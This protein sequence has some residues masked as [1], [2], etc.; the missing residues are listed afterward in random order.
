MSG[1]ILLV[2]DSAEDSSIIIS[3]LSGYNILTAHNCPEALRQ[4]DMNPDI[5]LL[6]LDI[7]MPD[8]GGFQVLEMLKKDIQ[9]KRLRV[10]ILTSSDLPENEIKGLQLGANDYLRRPLQKES[11]IACINMHSEVQKQESLEQKLYDQDLLFDAI[12]HQSPIGIFISHSMNPFDSGS[13]N[14]ANINPVFEK[15]TGRTKEELLNLGWAKIT[16]PD[17]LAE[18]MR[19]FEKLVAGKIKSYSMEKRYIKPDGSYI[20]VNMIV[21]S[22][23]FSNEYK[24][25]YIC[26]IQDITKQKLIEANLSESER[27]KSVLLS[28]L[29]GLAYRCKNDKEWTMM[30]VSAGC[31]ELTGYSSE[32]LLNN[33]EVSFNDIIAPE[34]R[35]ALSKE[36]KRIL[37]MRLP[38]K[39]EYE[40]IT[41]NKERK[42][43]LELGEGIFSETGEVEALEGI[44]IDITDRKQFENTLKIN[45]EHDRWTGLFNRNYLEKLLEGDFKYHNTGKRALVGINLSTVQSLTTTYGFHYAQDLIKNIVNTLAIYCTENRQLFNTYENQFVF[46]IKKYKDNAELI[47][48]CE[49]I[50]NAL[51]ALLSIERIGGGIGVVKI[52]RNSTSDADQVLKNLLIAS[53]KAM[54]LEDR[55]FGFCFY[56]SEVETKMSR[57]QEIIRELSKIAAD[58]NHG[59]LFLQYQPILDLKLN[60]ICGFEALARLKTE[61]LGLVPPAEFI[62][63]A[64][65][66]KLIIPI[67]KKVLHIALDF[68]RKLNE[69]GYTKLNIS[70][71][72]SVIQLLKDDFCTKL[73][74]IINETK[75][76]PENICLEITESVFASNYQ[77]INNIIG[78]LKET[79]IHIAIDD[80]GTGYSS[81][82][83]ERELNI[84]CLK[85][86]KQF[87]DNLLYEPEK[88]L[89]ANIVSMAHKLGHSAIAEGVEYEKQKQ[90]LHDCG[91]DKIQGYLISKPLDESMT[92]ELLEKQL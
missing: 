68:L 65:K 13:N 23:N 70:V 30:Y 35:A 61:K 55:E 88:A 44:I 76:Y 41:A 75:V 16:H 62:P 67:G 90:Y 73:F 64:E 14:K 57:E 78:D 34:Y 6:I 66:T 69:L 80:F 43:V 15:I 71:N 86:D 87:I 22:L 32:N 27:S 31:Y 84:N 56:D 40:I 38:F 12:F 74:E 21:S 25:N 2:N 20:W 1:K 26:L 4:I 52:D 24:F 54:E 58:E 3:T 72:V 79:G 10:I 60:Q 89:T 9:H 92:F 17:D 36:W 28:H 53:E 7:N 33:K 49:T 91:C 37:D 5:D 83:R 63:L 8:A 82:S 50:E 81:L 77:E 42:W 29:P 85:I 39:Y 51:E 45:N 46:Y 59:G 48:F 19:S 47:E 18:D 11:L